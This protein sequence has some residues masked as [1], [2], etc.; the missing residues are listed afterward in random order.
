MQQAQ[1][2]GDLQFFQLWV[3]TQRRRVECRQIRLVTYKSEH[4]KYIEL[5]ESSI[6]SNI[7]Y[8]TTE[9]NIVIKSNRKSKRTLKKRKKKNQLM[10]LNRY[11]R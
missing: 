6:K 2:N 7:I 1:Y 11:Y 4:W 9:W 10:I 3:V 5:N 8:L